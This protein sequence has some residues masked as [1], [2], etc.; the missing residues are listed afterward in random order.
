MFCFPKFTA[1]KSHTTGVVVFVHMP[2]HNFFF[3]NIK[4]VTINVLYHLKI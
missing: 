4:Y 1:G 2:V 3:L